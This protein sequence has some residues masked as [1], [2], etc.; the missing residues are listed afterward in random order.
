MELLADIAGKS[1]L[2]EHSAAEVMQ[3]L[4]QAD[5]ELKQLLLAILA[6]DQTSLSR[7]VHDLASGLNSTKQM[8]LEV[9]PD[10]DRIFSSLRRVGERLA[11]Y[12]NL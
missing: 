12:T 11:H 6:V 1:P 2:D 4:P 10:Y 8:G 3:L 7:E 5:S 9:L